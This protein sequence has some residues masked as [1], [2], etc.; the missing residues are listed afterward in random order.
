MLKKS[1]LYFSAMCAALVLISL[2]MTSAARACDEE[3]Q[4]LLTLY[5][6]S[7]LVVLARYESNGESK[8]S[9]EDEYGYT[10]DTERKLSLTKIYKGQKDLKTV[11][12]LFSEYHSNQTTTEVDSEEYVHEYEEYFDLSKIKIGGEYLFFLSKNKETGEYNVSDYMSG[13]KDTSGK[14]DFYEETFAEL[15]QIASAKENQ[16]ALLT[17]WIVKSIENTDTRDDGI[18]DLSESFYGLEYQEEDPNFK[19][20]GPFVINE[21]YGIYTVG[22]AKHL[23]QTQKARVSAVLYSMLQSA[24]FAETP[25]YAN[26]GISGI[27]SGISRSRLAV[28]AYNSLQT[29]GKDDIER[30]RVIM[31]FLTDVVADETL[32]KF[33][34][35][36]S[37]LE[38]KIEELK[39]ETTREAKQQLKTMTV[40]KETLLKNFDKRFKFLFG[41]NF[42]PVETAKS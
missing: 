2:L 34:Y 42:V 8:K 29:V 38:I 22:V 14:S 31:E 26:Y 21:G 4:T 12:F 30:K 37:E 17:E 23:T 39:K 16:Y 5:M 36:Y 24:W 20:K 18:R 28:H 13:V 11:S 32:S 33:Y 25:Q 19:D 35:D 27:L 3:P 9:F 1:R 10:L 15:E 6:N 7:D 41:R 40:S